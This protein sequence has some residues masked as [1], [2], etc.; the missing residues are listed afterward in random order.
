MNLAAPLVL[1]CTGESSSSRRWPFIGCETNYYTT[2]TTLSSNLSLYDNIK[3]ECDNTLFLNGW[4]QLARLNQRSQPL[5]SRVIEAAKEPGR[6]ACRCWL[7]RTFAAL[8]PALASA[9][10]AGK[11]G[12]CGMALR[13]CMDGVRGTPPSCPLGPAQ[14]AD[15]RR[16]IRAILCAMSVYCIQGALNKALF[17]VSDASRPASPARK[18]D[19]RSNLIECRN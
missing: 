3:L 16:W 15:R 17:D 19:S 10:Q 18:Y 7:I 6:L 2:K 9:R 4:L 1:C 12:E 11:I 14:I 8:A 13:R 5:L